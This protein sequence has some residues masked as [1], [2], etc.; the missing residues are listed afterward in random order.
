MMNGNLGDTLCE[1]VN[2]DPR[3]FTTYPVK[4]FLDTNVI[5]EGKPLGELPWAEIH[6]AGP[7]LLLLTP[8]ALLEIDSKKRDGRLGKIARAF[9]KLIVPVA[10]GGA[11]IIIH[12]THPMVA[13]TLAHCGRIPWSSYDDLDPKDGDSRIVMEALHT[14]DV[15]SE[16]KVLASQ[17]VNPLAIAS[18]YG[19]R[20]FHMPETWLR[21]PEPTQQ[22]KKIQRLQ[23]Q[24]RDLSKTEPELSIRIKDEV[25]GSAT[26]YRLCPL[27]S[28]ERS[29]IRDL[30]IRRDTQPHNTNSNFSV[31]YGH[32]YS[33][34]ERYKKY[35][36]IEVPQFVALFERKVELL[37]NQV[38]FSVE[39]SNV[40]SVRADNLIVEI[41]SS[42]GWIHDKFVY[43]APP[44]PPSPRSPVREL[45]RS[46]PMI[47][48]QAGRHDMEFVEGPDR[49][50]R[51]VANC[52]DFRHGQS[53][54]WE[55][56]LGLDSHTNTPITIRTRVTAAN[57]HGVVEEIYTLRKS[58]EEVSF[59]YL[60]DVNTL[61]PKKDFPMK[62]AMDMAFETGDFDLIEF[63]ETQDNG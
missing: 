7:I 48:L 28:S 31:L 19:L 14:H 42:E 24:I 18:R 43:T 27:T 13:L 58:V 5:L 44:V 20:T 36:E 30:I 51:I 61:Q 45:L 10:T 62:K 52:E 63:D 26:V 8:Q 17:D 2:S 46:I 55:G 41:E 6:A 4:L 49:S 50:S 29:E 47:G 60:I 15:P 9:N 1:E 16:Q 12:D 25:S 37:F 39:L 35:C 11:P 54:V 56:V 53:W 38:S 3:D 40:G 32:D 22:D 23:Q 34:A 59:S 33:L 21:Q 57:M